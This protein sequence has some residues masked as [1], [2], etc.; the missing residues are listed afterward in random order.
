MPI[1][2]WLIRPFCSWPH[3]I[4]GW[5]VAEIPPISAWFRWP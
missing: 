5:I 1:L 3:V 4:A 2:N